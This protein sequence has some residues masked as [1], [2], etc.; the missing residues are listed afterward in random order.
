MFLVKILTVIAMSLLMMAMAK[1][2]FG[3]LQAV[4][5]RV[6]AKPP[7]RTTRLAQDP[8][9]GIYYPEK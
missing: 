3:V 6:K 2:V 7:A 8:R 4:T 1:L 5:V 9:T